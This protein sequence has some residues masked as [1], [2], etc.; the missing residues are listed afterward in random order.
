MVGTYVRWI[1]TVWH[2]ILRNLKEQTSLGLEGLQALQNLARAAC[3]WHY[4]FPTLLQ[5]TM[6]IGALLKP[7]LTACT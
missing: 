1:R 5:M 3:L 4:Y 2:W 6:Q 7:N